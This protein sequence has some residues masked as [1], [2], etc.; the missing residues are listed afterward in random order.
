MIGPPSVS[1]L[2]PSLSL[3]LEVQ[4]AKISQLGWNPPPDQFA[5]MRGSEEKREI[6]MITII[7]TTT[8]TTTITII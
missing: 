2:P 8:T 5:E 4:L 6:M 3:L 1:T 7:T